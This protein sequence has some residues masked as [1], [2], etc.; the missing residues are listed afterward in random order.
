MRPG[1]VNYYEPVDGTLMPAPLWEKAYK[2]VLAR[3]EAL[4]AGYIAYSALTTGDGPS[5]SVASLLFGE[6]LHRPPM[7][8]CRDGGWYLVA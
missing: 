7:I 6:W 2:D 4:L 3:K 8:Q 5:L 1:A